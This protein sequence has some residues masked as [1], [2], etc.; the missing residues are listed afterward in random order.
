LQKLEKANLPFSKLQARLEEASSLLEKRKYEKVKEISNEVAKAVEMGLEASKLIV[1]LEEKVK[2]AEKE[3]IKMHDTKR[4]LSLAKSAIVREDYALA[5]SRMREA[6]LIYAIERK[7]E[8]NIVN[9][10]VRHPLQS[11]AYFVAILLFSVAASFVMKLYRINSSLKSLNLEKDILLG[12]IKEVQREC[13][14]KGKMDMGQYLE[15]M[16]QHERRLAE[17]VQKTVELETAKAALLRLRTARRKLEMERERLI[18]LLKKT[19]EEY[20]EKG[21]HETMVYKNRM[22]SYIA[23]LTEVEEE[24]AA[25]EARAAIKREK[26]K[27]FAAMLR[28]LL[29]LRFFRKGGSE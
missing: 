4:M 12:L 26:R 23:R 14:E 29:L 6:E 20:I 3:G 18:G 8:F 28:K 7:G 25:R 21:M 11:L 9:F 27:K 16:A 24:L 2:E 22:R 19:Q 15:A 13:F 17:V 1:L 10:V 5:L